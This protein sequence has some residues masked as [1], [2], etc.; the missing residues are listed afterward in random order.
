MNVILIFT[1]GLTYK[2]FIPI[3]DNLNNVLMIWI[4]TNILLN[5]Y[6]TKIDI[7]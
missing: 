4:I 5:V 6:L 1:K 3:I 7:W 2:I